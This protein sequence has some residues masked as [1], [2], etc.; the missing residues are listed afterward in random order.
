MVI[1]YRT[2]GALLAGTIAGA[3]AVVS[4][5]DRTVAAG[6]RSMPMTSGGS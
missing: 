2:R 5:G 4:A 6:S 1:S 3:L